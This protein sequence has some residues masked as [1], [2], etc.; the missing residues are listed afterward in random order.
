MVHAPVESFVCNSR[1]ILNTPVAPHRLARIAGSAPQAV[2]EYAVKWLDIYHAPGNSCFAMP[3]A[4]ESVVTRV[5]LTDS[6][7]LVMECEVEVTAEMLDAEGKAANSFLFSVIDEATSSAVTAIDFASRGPDAVSGVSLYLNTSFH[8]PAYLGSVLRFICTA[9]PS[10][11]GVT[12]CTCEVSEAKTSRL[13]AT[14]V[15][16]GMA[17]R[18]SAGS[19]PASRL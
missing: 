3:M 9:R 17:Q 1:R 18:I 2:K 5:E 4:S 10:V 13:V 7:E 15:F 12:N 6:V 8:N 14:G 19:L 16:S 11:G